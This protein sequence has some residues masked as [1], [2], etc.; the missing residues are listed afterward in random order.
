VVTAVA[1]TIKN[2]KEI[3]FIRTQTPRISG[4]FYL[5]ILKGISRFN[6]ESLNEVST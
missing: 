1:V 5:N 3:C 2:G 6:R 4:A